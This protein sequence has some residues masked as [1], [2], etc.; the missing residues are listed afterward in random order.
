MQPKIGRK[1]KTEGGVEEAQAR[2]EGKTNPDS[3]QERSAGRKVEN[4]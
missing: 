1:T 2:R 4:T 3:E